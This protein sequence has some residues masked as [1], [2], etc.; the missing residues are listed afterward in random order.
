MKGLHYLLAVILGSVALTGCVVRERRVVVAHPGG[1]RG[2]VYI[3][4]HRGR[5]GVWHPGH[6]RCP[7]VVE[8]IEVD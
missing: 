1:C 6:W 8:R 5:H 4:G 2:G 7:G 3:E